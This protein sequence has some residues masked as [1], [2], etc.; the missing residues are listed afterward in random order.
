MELYRTTE[1]RKVLKQK[2]KVPSC[3]VTKYMDT[4]S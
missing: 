4:E 2:D 1:A 3:I